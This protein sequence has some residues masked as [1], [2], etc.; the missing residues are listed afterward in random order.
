MKTSVRQSQ[1]ERPLPAFK[2][3]GAYG[4]QGITK[5]KA[6]VI[7]LP[8]ASVS[9]SETGNR[10][11][12]RAGE[13]LERPAG[14]RHIPG[15]RRALSVL[16]ALLFATYLPA[17]Y[18]AQAPAQPSGRGG[19]IKEQVSK[20]AT[21]TFI[22]VRFTNKTKVRGYLS[23]VE[24]DGFSFKEGSPARPTAR[25]AAFS[26]VKSVKVITKTHTPVA[27]WIAV[28]ALIAVAVVVVVA[29]GIER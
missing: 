8:A 11:L 9:L 1:S 7:N 12:T 22:E 16:L 19:T 13:K 15:A 23:S 2:A 29:V 21:G 14:G 25:Q 28:G 4:S 10:P 6:K 5:M 20:L 17:G 3:W 26:A 18:G 27:A 24:A